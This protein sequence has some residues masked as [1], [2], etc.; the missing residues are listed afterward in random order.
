[1]DRDPRRSYLWLARAT[2]GACRGLWVFRREG[3]V[4]QGLR[5]SVGQGDG[6]RS[7]RSRVAPRAFEDGGG[8]AGRTVQRQKD[9][10]N[11]PRGTQAPRGFLFEVAQMAGPGLVPELDVSDLA[12]SLEF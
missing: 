1:M 12:Q 8:V 2:Q 11:T 7:L 4:G 3:K 6:A 10:L 5:E 9:E